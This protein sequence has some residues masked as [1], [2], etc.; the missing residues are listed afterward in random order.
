M[1]NT[2]QCKWKLT[3][4]QKTQEYLKCCCYLYPENKSNQRL[5]FSTDFTQTGVQRGS[6][7]YQEV[8]EVLVISTKNLCFSRKS[9][10]KYYCLPLTWPLWDG[11]AGCV[12]GETVLLVY[13]LPRHHQ[14]VQV[15][16]WP[17]RHERHEGVYQQVPLL[18]Q[19]SWVAKPAIM[20]PFFWSLTFASLASTTLSA[21][22]IMRMH[23][24]VSRRKN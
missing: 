23:P 6:V 24:L 19:K 17:Q 10:F 16:R 15:P 20:L 9:L 3:K 21:V 13:S 11:S 14:T 1:V 4:Q 12:S 5:Q 18:G 8:L 2:T 7:P 22:I